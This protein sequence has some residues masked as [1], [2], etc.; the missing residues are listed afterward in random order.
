M[1]EEVLNQYNHKCPLMIMRRGDKN[2]RARLILMKDHQ[3]TITMCRMNFF[4][5]TPIVGITYR[6]AMLIHLTRV[7]ITQGIADPSNPISMI[8]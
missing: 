6:A 5:I 8:I 3:C 1:S 4:R 7:I 2:S